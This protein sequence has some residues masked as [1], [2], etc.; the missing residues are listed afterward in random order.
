MKFTLLV[1]DKIQCKKASSE[2]V[3]KF[4]REN[5]V[6]SSVA[7]A[8]VSYALHHDRCKDIV[9]FPGKGSVIVEILLEGEGIDEVH[10]I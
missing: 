4:L 5:C 1:D 2:K 3:R 10:T 9:E 7:K 6:G 8:L